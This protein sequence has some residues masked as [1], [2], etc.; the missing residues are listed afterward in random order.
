M[1]DFWN[2]LLAF[3]PTMVRAV[4]TAVAVAA[5]A[6]GLEL[7]PWFD[8]VNTAWLALYGII[9]ILQGL[10]TRPAVTP[11][12]K[13]VDAYSERLTGDEPHEW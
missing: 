9:P 3:E 12:A 10:I 6:F 11:N 13:A 1:K 8:Q 4:L 7:T 5:G 2:R